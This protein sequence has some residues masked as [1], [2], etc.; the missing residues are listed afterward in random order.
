MVGG[1]GVGVRVGSEVNVAEGRGIACVGGLSAPLVQAASNEKTTRRG[2]QKRIWM[3]GI[4][5]ILG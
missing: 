3:D 5:S 1:N 4:T 2:V